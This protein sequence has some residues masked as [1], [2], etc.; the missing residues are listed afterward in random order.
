MGGALGNW[1]GIRIKNS[2]KNIY[3]HRQNE[4]CGISN[5]F[6]Y[7]I[8]LLPYID[9]TVIQMFHISSMYCICIYLILPLY[10][11][12]ENIRHGCIHGPYHD[13]DVSHFQYVLYRV[14]TLIALDIANSDSIYTKG[15]HQTKLQFQ[16]SSLLIFSLSWILLKIPKLHKIPKLP[17]ELDRITVSIIF[18]IN[19]L[20]SRIS[21]FW[22]Y[23]T[24]LKMN[25]L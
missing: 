12:K 21:I 1:G 24:E 19:F 16:S 23:Q 2:I 6:S 18:S 9:P 13:T 15:K 22:K 8:Y 7:R 17:N 4:E 5:R 14:G 20:I 10:I 25:S 3:N 11:P